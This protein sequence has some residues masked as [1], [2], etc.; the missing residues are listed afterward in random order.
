[1]AP[2]SPAT[3]RRGGSGRGRF[4]LGLPWLPKGR[5]PQQR[6]RVGGRFPRFWIAPARPSPLGWG[7][8]PPLRL[9]GLRSCQIRRTERA[10]R[11]SRLGPSPAA[12]G[13]GDTE[14][15]VL[16]APP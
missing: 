5:A 11:V 16:P 3:Q 14:T 13:A 1:M 15:W 9:A 6:G 12:G 10:D 2:H 7:S 8:A 4:G